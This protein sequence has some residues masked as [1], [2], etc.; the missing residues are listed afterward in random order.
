[1]PIPRSVGVAQHSC[2]RQG[3]A[4]E[5]G[6][7]VA[8]VGTHNE[9]WEPIAVEVGREDRVAELRQPVTVGVD[10]IG[11]Q[12]RGPRRYLWVR[13]VAVI[14]SRRRVGLPVAVGVWTIEVV[15]VLVDPIH[16]GVFRP[17]VHVR[18]GVVTVS[19]LY[20][21]AVLI[22]V[23]LPWWI[24]HG[25]IFGVRPITRSASGEE[26]NEDD[27]DQR[28][29]RQSIPEPPSSMSL[30]RRLTDQRPRML[31]HFGRALLRPTDHLHKQYTNMCTKYFS[32]GPG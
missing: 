30:N 20:G 1:L 9:I 7:R 4:Q 23:I 5:D 12:L 14:A 26:D 29:H 19:L 27:E 31:C 8:T 6:D 17:R 3:R 21:V 13:V 11:T 2:T 10:P 32:V 16:G 24:R 22:D 15:A 25:P 18:I 28:F